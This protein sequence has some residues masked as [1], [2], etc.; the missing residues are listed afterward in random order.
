MARKKHLI[1]VHT[2]TGT[3]AP[4]GASLY[5]GEIAVQH[6]TNDP[7][8]WIKMGTTEASTAYEKFIGKTEI[9]NMVSATSGLVN[10]L[11]AVTLTG[12]TMNNSPVNVTNHVANLGT[13]ITAETQ[14]ST[15][16]T[17]T[18]N[19]VGS[20]SVS[21][22]KITSTMFSAASADQVSKL[23]AGTISLV[24]SS[25]A[26]VYS[27]AVSYVNSAI[28]GLDSSTAVTNGKYITGIA[29]A[30]GKISGIT[31]ATL[32]SVS[33]ITATTT[34]TGNVFTAVST[35]GNSMTFTKGMT[36]AAK[37]DLDSLSAATTAHTA[38]TTMHITS[39]E[40]T[41]WNNAWTSGVS[42]YTKVENL[43][44]RVDENEEVVAG[45]LNNL[46]NRVSVVETHMTGDY[47]PI[48]GYMLASGATEEELTLRE[49]D[50]VNEALGKLQKQ[51]LDNEEAIAAGLN[52]LNQRVTANAQAIARNTGVTQLS[53]AVRSLS[54][55]TYYGLGEMF[56]ETHNLSSATKSLSSATI[57]LSGAV[58]GISAKTSGILTINANGVEQGRYSP[59]ANT[60]I[61]LQIVQDVTGA[62]VLLTGYE[63][64]TGTTEEELAI[65]ATDTVN[66]AFGKI[67]KQNY[68][69][70]AV[71][72][73][74][75]NDLDERVLALEDGGGTDEIWKEIE[76]QE[77]VI[78]ASLNDLNSRIVDLSGDSSYHSSQ[79]QILSG[80]VADISGN[81]GGGGGG[82]EGA[83][84][85]VSITGTGN[86]ITNATFA[87]KQLTLTKGNVVTGVTMNGAAKTVTNGVVNLGTVLTSSTDFITTGST[88]QT[89]N[90]TLQIGSSNTSLQPN[91]IIRLGGSNPYLAIK[92]DS[93]TQYYLQVYQDKVYFGPTYTKAMSIDANGNVA[94]TGS[95]TAGSFVKSGGTSSQFLKADGSVDSTAYA[96]NA[97]LTA[98]TADTTVH[99]T[100]TEKSTWNGKANT[101]DIKITGL[102]VG[103]T[104][105]TVT[106][107]VAAV[108]TASTS[109]FGV[110]K[111][112]AQATS[113]LTNSNGT[114]S[115]ATGTGA[116]QVAKG[117]DFAAVSAATTAHTADT[118]IHVTAANKTTWDGKQDAI[119]D[120]ATIRNNASSGASAYT[121]VT[122]LSAAT[123][124]MSANVAK[125]AV[126]GVTVTGTGN[127]VTNAAYSNSA[128]TL[129]KGNVLTAETLTGV[130][131]AGTA[132]TLSSRVAPIPSASSS[133]F[134]VVKTGNFISNNNGTIAVATGTTNTTVAV[135]NHTHTASQVGALPTGT[136][137]DG[138]ADG[139]TRKLSN[140]ATTG[141]VNTHTGTTIPN[142][143]SGQM[144][145]PTV[146]A[147]D[148]G[149]ILRVVNGAWALVDPATIYSGSGTPAQSL[150]NDG[151]I[152]LQ[153]S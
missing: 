91:G 27:S 33:E 125:I 105:A 19:V 63:L 152:Y 11:S 96:T 3:T 132:V 71:V 145:L 60:T 118:T 120:L 47:I 65:V 151:D 74:A 128:L 46:N 78:A 59:S 83:V 133:A 40:R 23:S 100:S 144:H 26:S 123:T 12:V 110:V 54:A 119:S 95:S 117:S 122:A 16:K 31:E 86:A 15:A 13:V 70:E 101:S 84:T 143:T 92:Q 76:D 131:L 8:L 36:A 67:Q 24:A 85:G 149:K 51:S 44:K 77:L 43:T 55:A 116:N 79:I 68:D 111:V 7:G 139:T 121:G 93:G 62:D 97:N 126:T 114:I 29:I 134:G 22:H 2:S 25:A 102:T 57:N 66:E 80:L 5:L 20:I 21:N 52:D 82:G 9:T 115:V 146:S 136:T 56:D 94:T 89:K 10:D 153:T 150:G 142:R 137:L 107:K 140:Y 28:T 147:S 58:M 53:G 138:I 127:A 37:S 148:N 124:A 14:L 30:N 42:A 38:N 41:R 141:T 99:V 35:T 98:H 18:G 87:S 73:G 69:N 109:T 106:N 64:A 81:T 75:L 61:D 135:G 90:G 17:G 34:G 113:F 130:S 112:P 103:G 104:N 49:T 32:P 1:N 50:T 72:A 45:A 4:T 88:T 39:A 129:T 48:T 6:T 108:P